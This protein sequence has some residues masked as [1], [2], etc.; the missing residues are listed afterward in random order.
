MSDCSCRRRRGRYVRVRLGVVTG[1]RAGAGPDGGHRRSTP[2]ARGDRARRKG[3][4]GWPDDVP[5]RTAR[6]GRRVGPQRPGAG[7]AGVGRRGGY[8]RR[9]DRSNGGVPRCARRRSR[10]DRHRS[11]RS[12]HLRHRSP[13]GGDLRGPARA[14]RDAIVPSA[15][16]RR[17][18]PPGGH[19]H[20]GRPG[21]RGRPHPY[22]RPESSPRASAL[23]TESIPGVAVPP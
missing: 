8:V 16:R 7:G 13:G 17:A 4:C 15:P 1:E 14:D 19:R 21:E 22:P 6:R 10:A 3:A 9:R 23:A 2:R 20:H 5:A 18:V 11:V 12:R